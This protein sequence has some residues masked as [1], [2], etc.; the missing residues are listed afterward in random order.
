[1]KGFEYHKA[2]NVGQAMALLA[3]HRDNASLLAGGSDLLGRMKDGLEGPKLQIP[4]HLIDITGIK[5]LKGIAEQ[6]RGLKIGA[7]ATLSEIGSSPAVLAKYSLLAEAANKVGVPQIRNVGTLGGNLC[8]KPRCWYFRGRLFRDCFR[9]GGENCY[10][11]SGEN[12]YHAVFPAGN[13]CMVCPS[14]LAVALTALDARVEIATPKGIK[15][16]SMGQFYV[17]PDTNVLSETILNSDEMVVSVEI[18]GPPSG[19]RS[20][21]RKLKEREAFDF[22]LVSAAAVV[23]TNNGTVSEVRIVLGGVAPYPFRLAGAEAALT[24]KKISDAIAP[25]CRAATDG[26]QPLSS[27]GYKLKAIR[28]VL[29]EALLS[30]A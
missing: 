20:V 26:A 17:G 13:C 4:G 5:D 11:P 12:Q 25:V 23:R 3:R 22:A 29:E 9:K 24:G 14:D 16:V 18:P 10:A 2:T 30:L 19:L 15:P 8:Q 21:F 7:A 27:N 1:M 6:P 28:G